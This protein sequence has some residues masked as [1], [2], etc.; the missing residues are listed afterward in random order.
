[1]LCYVMLAM[2]RSA[3]EAQ[4]GDVLKLYNTR[5]SLISIGPS[6]P[7][8]TPDTRYRLDIVAAS[9]PGIW[10]TLF[11]TTGMVPPVQNHR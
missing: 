5:D 9:I 2:F 10:T 8:N 1:M 6:L 7:A 11:A 4:D 3:A